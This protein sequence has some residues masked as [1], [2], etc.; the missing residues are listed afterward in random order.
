[1]FYNNRRMGALP[2]LF[3]TG[4]YISV[5]AYIIANTQID[6][7][8]EDWNTQRCSIMGMML[9]SYIP[10]PK[11]PSTTP[12]QFSSDNFQFCLQEMVDSSM[13][14]V[15]VPIMGILSAQVT[16]ANTTNSSINN[17]RNSAASDVTSP[18]NNLMNIAW[19]RF[20]YILAQMLRIMYNLNSGFQRVFGITIASLFAGLST[21]KA[22]HNAYN[23]LIKVCI[24]VLVIIISLLFLIFFAISP[25]LATVII[26][27]VVAISAT[28]YSNQ[29]G[30]VSSGSFS[31]CVEPGTL[32]KCKG[33]WVPVEDIRVGGE[34]VQGRVTG[35]LQ[36]EGGPC[37]L[38][39][40]IKVSSTHIVYD[41]W[42]KT[43]VFAKDHS[44]AVGCTYPPKQVYSLTTSSRTWVIK[45]PQEEKELL[46]RD[47]THLP[48]D[49]GADFLV[50]DLAHTLLHKKN[51]RPTLITSIGLGLVGPKSV[52]WKEGV[53]PVAIDTIRIGD[54]LRDGDT[55]TRVTATYVSNEL[56]NA[57]G[58][59]ASAWIHVNGGWIHPVMHN[60][61]AE[62]FRMNLITE[63]GSYT[64]NAEKVRDLVEVGPEDL[65]EVEDFLL[66]LLNSRNE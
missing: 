34:L 45:S 36:G 52:V 9:A 35:I 22:V 5:F 64:M 2:L 8:R 23:L 31:N 51:V 54:I 61:S 16:A 18:F 55:V 29:M 24:I 63:S 21:F 48:S 60:E 56:G 6:T 7:L 59:N 41:I 1:M 27:V 14:L 3:V 58:P 65:Q 12:S 62:L 15:M 66:S 40:S 33:G 30:G 25:I 17:L 57:S 19:K 38:L 46:L 37:V 32:V 42:K 49:A 26:P 28:E 39:H 43:W 50:E 44:D 20:G 10:D 13:S 47:W 11:D 53:G 4:I